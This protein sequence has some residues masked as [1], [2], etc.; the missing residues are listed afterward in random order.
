MRLGNTCND[1]VLCCALQYGLQQYDI[2]ITGVLRYGL[3]QYGSDA[4]S[5]RHDHHISRRYERHTVQDEH[6]AIREIC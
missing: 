5:S 6:H 3:Q 2:V 1:N 4:Y